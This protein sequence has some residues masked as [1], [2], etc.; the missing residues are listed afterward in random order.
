ML[1]TET[2]RDGNADFCVEELNS[3]L[4]PNRR[5]TMS[6]DDTLPI[7]ILK[8]QSRPADGGWSFQLGGLVEVL[9]TPHHKILSW[10]KTVKKKHTC[11]CGNESSCSLKCGKFLN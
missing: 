8:K 1:T 5:W 7:N 2:L 4:K 11:D 6:Y 10:G 3:H 9:T